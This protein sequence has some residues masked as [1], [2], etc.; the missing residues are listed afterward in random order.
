MERTAVS[1]TTTVNEVAN[2][3]QYFSSIE[4]P[5]G[6]QSVG[7]QTVTPVTTTGKILELQAVSLYRFPN[8]TST[9]QCFL[10]VPVTTLGGT[11]RIPGG[12]RLLYS[13]RCG[14][15]PLATIASATACR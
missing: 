15:Q 9:L 7:Q 6:S 11:W 13:G 1:A 4:F 8:S 12:D 3:V 14:H 2:G 10:A 5:A